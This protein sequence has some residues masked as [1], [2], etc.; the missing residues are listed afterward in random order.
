MTTICAVIPAFNAEAYIEETVNSLLNQTRTL[1]RIVIVDDC[2]QDSTVQT[3]K[4]MIKRNK[5]IELV[6]LEQNYGAAYARNVGV[7]CSFEDWILFMD[8]DDIAH[9][10]LVAELINYL[11]HLNEEEDEEYLLAHPNY[12]HVDKNGTVVDEL[13]FGRQYKKEEALGYLLLRNTI[14][15][16]SGILVDRALFQKVGG[17]NVEYRYSEDWDLWLRLS[18]YS[19]IAHLDKHLIDIRRHS[20]NLSASMSKMHEY[21]MKILQSYPLEKIKEA[22]FR[23]TRLTYIQNVC[24]YVSLLFRLEKWQDGYEMLQQLEDDGHGK[25]Q[26]MVNFLKGIYFLKTGDF[27]QAETN[28]Q[29]I[30]NINP[31]DGAALNNLGALS[32]LKGKWKEGRRYLLKALELYPN[33][34]DASYNL[35]AEPPY[36]WQAL[37]FTWRKL[38][39]KLISYSQE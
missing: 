31:Y 39:P 8:S 18:E 12:R 28:F 22:V 13:N 32:L 6:Q 10:A 30:I 24:D 20:D 36:D 21:E 33:Y 14:A 1:D 27:S 3:V 29:C 11:E 23:R 15:T 5:S 17:F 9:P 4:R 35:R 19:G 34:F 16:S 2:S 7:E 25:E 38:R 37:R 26:E